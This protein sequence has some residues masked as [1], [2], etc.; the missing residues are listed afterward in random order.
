MKKLILAVCVLMTGVAFGQ[1]PRNPRQ[2]K[3]A[4]ALRLNNLVMN[5]LRKPESQ[6]TLTP[7]MIKL[8]R[9]EMQRLLDEANGKRVPPKFPTFPAPKP[10]P[11]PE[12]PFVPPPPE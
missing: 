2:A 11:K 7:A 10:V 5:E 9:E 1:Q 12:E 6:R 4:Q 8:A 3:A